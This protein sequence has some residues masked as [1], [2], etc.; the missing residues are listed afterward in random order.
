MVMV[1]GVHQQLRGETFRTDL[2]RERPI[3]RGHEALWNERARGEHEQHC[4]GNERAPD[5][6]GQ[7]DAHRPL[8]LFCRE[9]PID[10]TSTWRVQRRWHEPGAVHT[11]KLTCSSVA[12]PI[13][14]WR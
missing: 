14:S 13:S 11:C 1:G 6:M 10:S 4:T 12:K 9:Y 2:N 8:E 5:F 3:T 7:T